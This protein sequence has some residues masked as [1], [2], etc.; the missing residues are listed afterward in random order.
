MERVI[1]KIM[2]AGFDPEIQDQMDC[3]DYQRVVENALGGDPG[4]RTVYVE[5]F[6]EVIRN[7]DETLYRNLI[8]KVIR[9]VNHICEYNANIMRSIYHSS[10]TQGKGVDGGKK[11]SAH[12]T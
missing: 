10:K 8:R 3:D 6:F 1:E 12:G 7:L 4:A 5:K 11:D 2:D 9:H